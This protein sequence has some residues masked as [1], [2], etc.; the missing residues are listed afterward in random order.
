MTKIGGIEVETKVSLTGLLAVLLAFVALVGAWNRF[1]ARVAAAEQRMQ[2]LEQNQAKLVET[3]EKMT[4]SIETLN[5]TL[6]RLI[7]RMDDANIGTSAR[8]RQ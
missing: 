2:E 1:D 7:Q 4:D 8:H 3:Q 6:G 5:N